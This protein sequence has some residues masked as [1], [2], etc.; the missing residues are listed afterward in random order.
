MIFTT[1]FSAIFITLTLL[2]YLA[3]RSRPAR[4]ALVLVASLLF[5]LYFAGLAGLVPMASLAVLA[6]C[7][8]LWGNTIAIQLAIAVCVAAL[9][10]YKYTLFLAEQVLALLPSIWSDQLLAPLAAEGGIVAPLAISFFT[11]ELV[12]Y[13][14]DIHRGREPVRNPLDFAIF[15]FFFPSFAAGPIKRYEQ[16][17]PALEHGLSSV[18]IADV[19]AGLMRV[20]VGFFK[21]VVIADNLSPAIDFWDDRF[22]DLATMDRWLVFAAIAARILLDFSG[23][24]DIAIGLARMMGI[25]LPENFNWPYLATSLQDF[26]RRWHISLSSWIR[27]YVYI[28]LGGSRRSLPR[29]MLNGLI[30]F[31]LCGLWHGPAWH[32]ILWGLYHGAGLVVSANY[33]RL[34]GRSGLWLQ[35]AMRRLPWLGRG[36]TLA[37]VSVGWL[38]FFYPVDEASSMLILLFTF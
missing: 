16:F 12:H 26:W 24:S 31:A 22:A 36:L 33:P 11:F 23:Y 28:P 37:F 29:T 14:Y 32:F 20:G 17:V 3:A 5:Y 10:F 18:S 38:Y 9:L 34:P 27:D 25:R 2:V 35:T 13:L 21:K 15:I 30:A 7:V 4:K 1:Y 8:A 19:Q 6:Y